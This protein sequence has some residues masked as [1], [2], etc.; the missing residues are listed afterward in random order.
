MS[1][2]Y[3]S[4]SATTLRSLVVGTV[5]CAAIGTGAAYGSN[6]IGGSMLAAK[7]GHSSGSR[8]S[9]VARM[10]YDFPE[11]AVMAVK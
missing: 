4:A 5:L 2:S 6:V 7:K 8:A 9:T 11:R 10:A 1:E 3:N